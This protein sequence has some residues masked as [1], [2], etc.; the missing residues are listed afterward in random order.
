MAKGMDEALATNASARA[1]DAMLAAAHTKR[2]ATSAMHSAFEGQQGD[3]FAS[4]SGM[5]M[6]PAAFIHLAGL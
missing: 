2:A 1:A 5:H 6:F 3:A 4:A